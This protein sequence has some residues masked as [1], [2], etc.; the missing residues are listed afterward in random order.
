MSACP[1]SADDVTRALANTNQRPEELVAVVATHAHA[2][3]V[4]GVPHLP[5]TAAGHLMLPDKD[6]DYAAGET[7]RSPGPLD[8]AEITPVMGDQP[9]DLGALIEMGQAAGTIGLDATG[10]KMPIEPKGYLTDGA[11]LAGVPD[12][13]II[14]TP[15]HTDDSTSLYCERTRTLLSGDAV[16]AVGRRAWCNPEYVDAEL[17]EQTEQRLR[18][19]DVEVLLPGHGRA[20][21]RTAGDA[22][23]ALVPR[24]PARRTA[25]PHALPAQTP[26]TG[27]CM[28]EASDQSNRRGLVIG[29][30]RGG[31]RRRTHR[32]LPGGQRRQH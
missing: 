23:S 32:P 17:S 27:G 13:E 6:R 26:N 15:G 9:F 28:T 8:V 21:G 24:T 20:V 25:R 7:P 10:W 18:A 1:A 3:H 16:L 14:A 5:E 29:A 19:L 4:G 31:G 2:D 30:V 12:W 22:G 11:M